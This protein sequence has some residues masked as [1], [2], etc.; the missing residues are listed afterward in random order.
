M[1]KGTLAVG[2]AATGAALSVPFVVSQVTNAGAAGV[3][4]SQEQPGAVTIQAWV[5]AVPSENVL[6]GTLWGCVKI[7]GAINDQSG[8]PAWDSDSAYSAPEQL[9]GKA[10]ATSTIGATSPTRGHRLVSAFVYR[11]EPVLKS[12]R[13]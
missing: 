10:A 3:R 2:L 13:G 7:S 4:P 12:R 6:S 8:G 11:G 5:D 1:E 9:Q